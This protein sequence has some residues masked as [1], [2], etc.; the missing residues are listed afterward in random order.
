MVISPA[1]HWREET[2]RS[3]LTSKA[4]V[5]SK[6]ASGSVDA[7]LHIRGPSMVIG[8][9]L[10]PALKDCAGTVDVAQNFLHVSILQPAQRK[11]TQHQSGNN[12]RIPELIY[13]WK[14]S[15]STIPQVSR[16]VDKLVSH[17][18][19]YQLSVARVTAARHGSPPHSLAKF[20]VH[21][22]LH[23]K[24]ARRLTV[25]GQTASVI[26]PI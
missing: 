12:K 26:L 18:H 22:G 24:H 3:A 23:P 16:T 11:S 7:Y 15:D 5:H 17:F 4:E 1:H 8:L 14:N 25:H 20:C 19:L 13:T 21:G 6:V 2:A 10:H 9:P